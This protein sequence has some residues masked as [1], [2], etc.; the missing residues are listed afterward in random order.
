MKLNNEAQKFNFGNMK[1]P[2]QRLTVQAMLSDSSKNHWYLINM[3]RLG[4]G[5]DQFIT[6][7]EDYKMIEEDSQNLVNI[8]KCSWGTI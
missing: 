3:V 4:L 7:A 1:F 5:I 8:L 2:F 6:N